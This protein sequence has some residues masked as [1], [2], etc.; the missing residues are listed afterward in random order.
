VLAQQ[1]CVLDKLKTNLLYLA[2]MQI[3]VM[4]RSSSMPVTEGADNN[5]ATSERTR[6]LACMQP[7]DTCNEQR[8][9][10][11]TASL[12]LKLVLSKLKNSETIEHNVMTSEDDSKIWKI[13]LTPIPS[14]KNAQT[15]QQ[16]Q[17]Q[18]SLQLDTVMAHEA[19]VKSE[20]GYCETLVE[21]A[22]FLTQARLQRKTACDEVLKKLVKDK[23]PTTWDLQMSR[24]L[25]V[26]ITPSGAQPMKLD[27]QALEYLRVGSASG[28]Q[29]QQ[30]FL[31]F[32]NSLASSTVLIA[33]QAELA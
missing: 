12:P 27:Q 24:A 6:T 17:Q 16:Q 19:W 21:A 23:L 2:S 9:H 26:A 8:S 3:K 29:A 30:T 22:T 18:F 14:T 20:L 13:I 32:V 10:L 5:N 33:Q 31:L 1:N 25:G 28:D 7:S 11:F 15:L 4:Y